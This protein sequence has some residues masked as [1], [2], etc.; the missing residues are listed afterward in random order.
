MKF[1]NTYLSREH[2]FWLGIE[3]ESGTHFASIPVSNQM[4][5]YV[6]AY[7]ITEGEYNTF[8]ADEGAA[9]A[10][11]ESCRRHEQDDRLFLRPGSDRGVPS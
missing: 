2:R 7:K 11:V 4:V 1:E 8:L 6:E 5:D 3:T 9:V 10:F